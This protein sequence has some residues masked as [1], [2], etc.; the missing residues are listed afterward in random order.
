MSAI[1]KVIQRSLHLINSSNNIWLQNGSFLCC[2]FNLNVIKDH[3]RPFSDGSRNNC[4]SGEPN[5]EQ[6][7]EGPSTSIMERTKMAEPSLES[8]EDTTEEDWL[9]RLIKEEKVFLIQPDF[10]WGKGRFLSKAVS[11]RLG[12]A[13]ALIH[14]ISKWKVKDKQIEP[15]HELNPKFFFGTGKLQ[16][17]K[18][19]V[20]NLK[21]TQD[22]TSVFVNTGKLSGKQTSSLEDAFGCTVFDRYRVVLEIFKERART[23]E[24]KMQVR[25]AGLQYQRLEEMRKCS[26]CLF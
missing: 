9:V 22:I 15:I 6:V 13:E 17:L 25:L 10:K 23:K 16:E 11:N 14:S 18:N 8:E 3:C 4:G 7:Q 19:K 26:K 1:R 21:H 2:V 12:E 20:G 5:I 24:A